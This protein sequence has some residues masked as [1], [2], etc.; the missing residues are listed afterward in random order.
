MAMVQVLVVNVDCKGGWLLISGPFQLEFTGKRRKHPSTNAFGGGDL[1]LDNIL[2]EP[3]D[4]DDVTQ[5]PP[6]RELLAAH[7]FNLCISAQ[8]P[9]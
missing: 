3:A 1:A 9:I 6:L 8:N 7:T 2:V 4:K 5:G